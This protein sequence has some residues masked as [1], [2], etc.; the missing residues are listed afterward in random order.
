MAGSTHGEFA[1]WE[2]A[3]F[4]LSIS[5]ESHPTDSGPTSIVLSH[6]ASPF[7]ARMNADDDL[8]IFAY[9]H[10]YL[11]K[12][13]FHGN[14]GIPEYWVQALDPHSVSSRPFSAGCRFDAVTEAAIPWRHS[15]WSEGPVAS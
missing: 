4:A 14:L 12:A 5:R 11:R 3:A 9:A 2:P 13:N 15:L 10:E 6:L 1:E 8:Q 7:T